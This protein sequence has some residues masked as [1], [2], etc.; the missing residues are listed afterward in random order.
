MRPTRTVLSLAA[1]A[2][3]ASAPVALAAGSSPAPPTVASA[4]ATGTSSSA[5]TLN[6]SVNPNGQATNYAFQ[7]GPTSGY[8]HE[9]PLSAAGSATTAA[10]R[11]AALAGLAS[12]TT[13]H[14][15]IIAMSSA[16][17][18]VGADEQFTTS[19]TAPAPSPAP[20]AT[21]GS[22]T[23]VGQSSATVQGTVN[24]AGQGTTY[25]F[26][27]GPTV[28]YGFETAPQ[29]GG[30]GSASEPVSAQIGSL[31]SSTTY[32]YRLVAVSSG[33][34]A[35]GSDQTFKTTTPPSVSTGLPSAVRAS[36]AQLDGTVNPQGQ[37]TMYWFQ[38]GTSTAYGQQTRPGSAGSGS[39]P[40]SVH[41]FVGGLTTNST[42][43]YRLVAASGGGLSYGAD[44]TVTVGQGSHAAFMGHMGFVSPGRA[45]GVAVGCFGGSNSCSGHLTISHN[46]TTIGQRD[47]TVGPNSGD[48][49]DMEL[50]RQGMQMLG[51]NHVFGLLPVTVSVTTSSGQKISEVIHLARW[52]WH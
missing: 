50:S 36:S 18:S 4:P 44:Q 15:R 35:L 25:Y 21:T 22:S 2:A 52:V 49:Q 42:Y 14:F 11:S 7:W 38:Y 41:A 40:E 46:G 33:G 30:S 47:F 51:A 29:N 5:T 28:N 16:G 12:G 20:T 32:H 23:G 8:G 26:E 13:Y 37:A 43:H 39:S 1:L 31:A 48:F 45:V 6:G 9:T 19:G 34:T 3:I 17:T 24:P 10:A 27:Y